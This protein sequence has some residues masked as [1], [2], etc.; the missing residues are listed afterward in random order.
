MQLFRNSYFKGGEGNRSNI[1]A[2]HASME[3]HE[4]EVRALKAKK[5]T[6]L[7]EQQALRRQGKKIIWKQEKRKR[8]MQEDEERR[9]DIDAQ[10][11]AA[12][13]PHLMKL[14]PQEEVDKCVDEY[15]R[16]EAWLAELEKEQYDM[17]HQKKK[18]SSQRSRAS[19]AVC[20]MYRN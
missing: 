18:R 17:I 5:E 12:P 14:P 19:K 15:V 2:L 9:N 11:A 8:W 3:Q 20:Y 4:S 6:L 16:A 1:Y 10:I 13:K 7:A